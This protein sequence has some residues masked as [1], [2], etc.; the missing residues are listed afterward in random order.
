MNTRKAIITMSL[1]FNPFLRQIEM[2]HQ[3]L[4]DSSHGVERQILIPATVAIMAVI[5]DNGPEG[6][7]GPIYRATGAGKWRQSAFVTTKANNQSPA[8]MGLLALASA[9]LSDAP[10]GAYKMKYDRTERIQ[11]MAGGA[12]WAADT[13]H[14]KSLGGTPLETWG[15]GVGD[16][17]AILGLLADDNIHEN[18]LAGLPN[19]RWAIRLPDGGEVPDVG[20]APV[21]IAGVGP[22]FFRALVLGASGHLA[23]QKDR[24]YS[25]SGRTGSGHQ[26]SGLH[27]DLV[28]AARAMCD[29]LTMASQDHGL[30]HSSL[31]AWKRTGSLFASF[32]MYGSQVLAACKTI[33]GPNEGVDVAAE[34]LAHWAEKSQTDRVAPKRAWLEDLRDKSGGP[35][36]IDLVQKWATSTETV[37]ASAVGAVSQ[38][39][40]SPALGDVDN[41]MYGSGPCPLPQSAQA[42]IIQ[43]LDLMEVSPVIVTEAP[44]AGRLAIDTPDAVRRR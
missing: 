20:E 12:R 44:I 32:V 11:P 26:I 30:F 40:R 2:D 39:G 18:P 41:W 22:G 6:I 24:G 36:I 1:G 31:D 16:R 35:R 38:Y 37:F 43:V 21:G 19:M 3:A 25:P 33:L 10:D 4:P 13:G 17:S 23:R 7:G 15:A 34:V 9:C 14:I 8:T 28:A 27:G 5:T 42:G 29:A